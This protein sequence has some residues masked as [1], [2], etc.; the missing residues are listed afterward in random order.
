MNRS[1]QAGFSFIE[2]LVVMGIISVL[3]SMVVV[4]VPMIQERAK[5]AQ[6]TDN[7]RSLY[8]FMQ[9]RVTSKG[10]KTYR[11]SGKNFTLSPVALGDLD[12]REK[13]NLRIL[14]SPGDPIRGIEGVELEDYKAVT[15]KALKRGDE[16]FEN[17]TS[18]AGRRNA[19]P[20]FMITSS[21]ESRGTLI[22]A[23][24]DDGPI[25]HVAGFVA[26]YSNG[27]VEFFEWNQFDLIEPEDDKNPTPWL[28]ED[29]G[30]EDL[31]AL[32]SH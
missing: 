27:R 14:F 32:S 5:R 20:D 25:H 23:D 29:A 16:G 22:L 3:V 31:R 1:K 17:L 9:S 26:A 8:L 21:D 10:W 24:D 4:V 7:L 13:A 12:R 11:Y 28:G 30:N 15:P 6:S 18:Y 19:D 2:I